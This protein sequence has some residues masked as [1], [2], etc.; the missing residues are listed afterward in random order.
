MWEGTFFLI[1]NRIGAKHYQI[2]ACMHA[3]VVL[4]IQFTQFHITVSLLM[5]LYA[6]AGRAGGSGRELVATVMVRTSF[7]HVYKFV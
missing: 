2:G 5:I 3:F 7:F 6:F 4:C 1:W